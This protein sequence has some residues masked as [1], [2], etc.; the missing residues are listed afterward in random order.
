MAK[1][2]HLTKKQRSI[3]KSLLIALLAVLCLTIIAAVVWKIG[4]TVDN[5]GSEE[6]AQTDQETSDTETGAPDLVL[7][8]RAEASYEEWLAAGMVVS[9]SM[10]YPEFDLKGIYLTGETELAD[11]QTSNGA[12]VVFEV[13]GTQRAVY[14]FP[15]K[16]ERTESGTTDL[17][18]KDLGFSAFEQV[19]LERIDVAT[20]RR[21]T[22]EDLDELI[23]Q[24]IL[25]SLYEH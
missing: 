18:T 11:K 14:S 12:Y 21:V 13:E 7:T 10:L 20:C 1:G 3:W 25:V 4:S 5:P 17:Y 22:M 19:D 23:Q 2:R 24:S 8:N 15:L 6:S 16:A 9:V